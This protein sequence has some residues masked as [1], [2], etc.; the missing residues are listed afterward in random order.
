MNH[1]LQYV[2]FAA[3]CFALAAAAWKFDRDSKPKR[4][5]VE[6]RGSWDLIDEYTLDQHWHRTLRDIRDLP[7]VA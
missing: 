6:V 7:E 4:I 2:G 3:V 1:V 5:V